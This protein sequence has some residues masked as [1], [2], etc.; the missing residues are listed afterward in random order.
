MNHHHYTLNE[1]QRALIADALDIAYD[2]DYYQT[3]R[4]DPTSQPDCTELTLIDGLK[5][6]FEA[7]ELTEPLWRR[8][9][10]TDEDRKNMLD[11][12]QDECRDSVKDIAQANLD[13][14][15]DMAE[16]VSYADED[17]QVTAEL[18][19]YM[20]IDHCD[21]DDYENS[22]APQHVQAAKFMRRMGLVEGTATLTE[23]GRKYLEE[24]K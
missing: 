3:I 8:E 6:M 7:R 13:N 12:M 20:S 18:L 14:I 4:D 17:P 22:D 2:S 5:K 9:P 1:Y 15:D 10:F 21:M 24:Y 11:M 16:L 19:H 23:V